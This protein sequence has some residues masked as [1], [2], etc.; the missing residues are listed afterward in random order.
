MSKV[1]SK[2]K[3]A[4][5]VNEAKAIDVKETKSEIKSRKAKIKKQEKKVKKLKKQL[6]KSK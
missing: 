5:A 4:K 1:K 2:A 6:K 3:A